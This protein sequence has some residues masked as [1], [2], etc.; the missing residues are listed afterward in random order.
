MRERE[1]PQEEDKW[2][3]IDQLGQ[4]C[5]FFG[6]IGRFAIT[7]TKCTKSKKRI[8]LVYIAWIEV[9]SEN[10]SRGLKITLFKIFLHNEIECRNLF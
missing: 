4:D 5:L 8:S 2:P 1:R 7:R 9:C 3:R 6:G 10:V